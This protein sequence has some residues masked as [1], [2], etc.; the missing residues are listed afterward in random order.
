MARRKQ[1]N[2]SSIVATV[3]GKITV[4]PRCIKCQTGKVMAV[5]TMQAQSEKRSDYPLR[6]IGFD[7]MA[8]SV[9]LLQK[10]QV[11]TVMGKASYWQGYQLTVSA[12]A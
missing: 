1:K 3:T 7:E 10:G 12:I 6:V 4:A 11:I 2:A 8:L 9:M 5:A